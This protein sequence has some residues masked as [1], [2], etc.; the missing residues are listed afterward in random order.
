M[1]AVSRQLRTS[2]VW[3][4][5]L[6]TVVACSGG[7]AVE[8]RRFTTRVASDTLVESFSRTTKRLSGVI[9]SRADSVI[10]VAELGDSGLVKSMD[11]T[12][13]SHKTPKAEVQPRHILVPRGS[14]PWI[15][16]S[17]ALL[18]QVLL[19]VRALGHDS[20]EVPIMYVENSKSDILKVTANGSD[21][22]VM[23]GIWGGRSQNIF[24]VS[25][26]T[27]LRVTGMTLP[28]TGTVMESSE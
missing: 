13:R 27:A 19:R 24:R 18:E 23:T 5:L 21:S 20:V 8:T 26:D 28:R 4:A 12:V 16:G 22:V 9:N 1:D 3:A 15:T 14:I 17:G 10:Y 6:I 11:L 25:I 2:I 7:K